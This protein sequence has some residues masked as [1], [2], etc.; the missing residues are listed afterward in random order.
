[1]CLGARVDPFKNNLV[2]ILDEIA[3]GAFDQLEKLASLPIDIR[4]RIV[5]E[6]VQRACTCQHVGN[7]YVSHNALLRIPSDLRAS[8]LQDAVT[9]TL[10]LDDEW[11]YR[12]LVEL[13]LE[14]APQFVERYL[15]IGRS[16]NVADVREAAEDFAKT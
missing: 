9:R 10:D 5:D 12:R 15:E 16:S 3:P 14:I 6:L 1:M 11:E 8:M 4:S 13:L 2:A 7:I